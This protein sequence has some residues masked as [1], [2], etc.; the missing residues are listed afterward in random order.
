MADIKVKFGAITSG[1]LRKTKSVK[2][3]LKGMFV[4]V[5][6]GVAAVAAI[7][8]GMFKIVS[9][10]AKLER[11]QQTFE[12]LFK[13]AEKAKNVIKEIRDFSDI[14]PF[15]TSELLEAGKKLATASKDTEELMK[16]MKMLGDISAGSGVE[17]NRI[18]KIFVKMKNL[19]RL[20]MEELNQL[21]EN[22]II[23]YERLGQQVGIKNTQQLRKFI[24]QGRAGFSDVLKIMKQMTGEGGKFEDATSKLAGTFDGKVSTMISVWENFITDVG[25]GG[26]PLGRV[27]DALTRGIRVLSTFDALFAS[28]AKSAEATADA[29]ELISG[30][31]SAPELAAGKVTSGIENPV[32]KSLANNIL[33]QLFTSG[34]KGAGTGVVSPVS[35]ADKSTMALLDAAER[36]VSQLEQINKN[37]Q[38][39]NITRAGGR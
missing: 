34:G 27:V 26:K 30:I 7:G 35:A 2:D 18:V 37:Q 8:V 4:G 1:F 38:N 16:N 3:S 13:S 23:S 20:T 19:G 11:T 29:V 39:Q 21:A 14:T 31:K 28:V 33:S 25:A 10:G 9:A 24:E 22:N 36:Q 17:M 5:A 6:A 32:V 12:I 15:K